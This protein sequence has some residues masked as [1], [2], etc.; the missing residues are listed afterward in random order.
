MGSMVQT[1]V[2]R[3]DGRR[4]VLMHLATL[5][6]ALEQQDA[7]RLREAAHK[8]CGMIATFSADAS[9]MALKREESAAC[10]RLKECRPKF[11]GNV[12]RKC[13]SGRLVLHLCGRTPGL[14]LVLGLLP[15]SYEFSGEQLAQ[16]VQPGLYSKRGLKRKPLE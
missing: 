13:K 4:A 11:G 15:N 7:P 10:G 3:R 1:N 8:I 6:D 16:F 9:E 14:G 5:E 12:V 2:V